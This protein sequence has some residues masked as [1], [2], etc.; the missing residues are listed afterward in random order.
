MKASR[1]PS[2]TAAVFD[3]S[4][5][6]PVVLDHLVGVQHVAPDL[7]APAGLD[8]LAPEA[9]QLDLLLLERAARAGAPRG[10]WSPS[11]GSGSRTAR[12]GQ[13]TTMPVGRCVR[14]TA[15]SVFL[16]CCPPAPGR[17][18]RVDPELVPVELDLDVVLDLGHDLDE[19]ERGLA[20]LLGVVRA[21]PDE[22]VDAALGAQ[23]AVGAAAV[24]G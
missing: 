20:A 10:P 18:E 11:P 19:R 24:H 16:T 15:E 7:V 22:A 14:R 21:D 1:S 9:A 6:G 12:S 13:V 17:A 3:V 4:M 8:V 23:P 5:L 2:R